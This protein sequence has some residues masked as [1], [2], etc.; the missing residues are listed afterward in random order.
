MLSYDCVLY[1]CNVLYCIKLLILHDFV[2]AFT[3]NM[4]QA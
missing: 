1:D 3:V 2:F 4:K